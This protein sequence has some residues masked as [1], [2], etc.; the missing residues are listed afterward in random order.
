MMEVPLAGAVLLGQEGVHS[1]SHT[2][3]SLLV[4]Q[5]VHQG[6]ADLRDLEDEDLQVH[7]AVPCASED[8][9]L[10]LVG[11]GSRI[12]DTLLAG[13]DSCQVAGRIL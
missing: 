6:Q 5:G 2:G 1:E 4:L 7:L 12:L 8:N 3:D 10:P 9:I 13:E 11:L